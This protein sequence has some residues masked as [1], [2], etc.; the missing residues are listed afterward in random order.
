MIERGLG[1]AGTGRVLLFLEHEGPFNSDAILDHGAH[2]RRLISLLIGNEETAPGC[3]TERLGRRSIN[4]LL[5]V[6]S[7]ILYDL[8]ATAASKLRL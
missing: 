7:C 6:S 3:D 8:W 1:E 5:S 4:I 2:A